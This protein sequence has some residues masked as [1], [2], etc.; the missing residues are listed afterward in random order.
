[1]AERMKKY[2]RQVCSYMLIASFVSFASACG[3]MKTYRSVPT[4]ESAESF[5]K[6][7]EPMV[8]KLFV[9]KDISFSVE[10]INSSDSRVNVWPIPFFVIHDPK[11][12]LPKPF[13]VGIALHATRSG[14]L[15][16]PSE[17]HYW[18]NSTEKYNPRRIQGPR[19]CKK[20]FYPLWENLP[21]QPIVLRENSYTCLLLEFDTHTP[22]PSKTFF[23][24]IQGLSFEGVKRP[25]PIIQFRESTYYSPINLANK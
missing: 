21:I 14:G 8:G 11:Q 13:L 9:F 4:I 3:G 22:N 19:E 24:E 5:E 16:N 23:V 7:F 12:D 1:M 10:P 25:L 15:L 18:E 17:V 2:L 6:R 20:P